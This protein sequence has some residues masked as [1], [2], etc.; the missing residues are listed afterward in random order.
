MHTLNAPRCL[1]VAGQVRAI[2]AGP[3]HDPGEDR[4]LLKEMR[5]VMC[6]FLVAVNGTCSAI[7]G[8]V[9][10]GCR[11]VP[12]GRTCVGV[13]VGCSRFIVR[14]IVCYLQVGT[15]CYL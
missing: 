10:V 3:A 4:A 6:V 14:I 11:H 1:L 13:C 9:V 12:G 2:D 8:R 7:S 5:T 15:V